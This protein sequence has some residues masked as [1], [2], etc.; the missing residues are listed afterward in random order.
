[1]AS[2]RPSSSSIIKHPP[3]GR[4]NPARRGMEKLDIQM[5]GGVYNAVE[6]KKSQFRI[7]RRKWDDN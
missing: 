4:E 7:R 3:S 5:I 1:M 6:D 2:F